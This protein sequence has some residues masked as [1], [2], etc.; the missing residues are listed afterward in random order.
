MARY[1]EAGVNEFIIDQ[2]DSRLFPVLERIVDDVLPRHRGAK[3][4]G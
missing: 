2:P 4:G 1:R 3:E